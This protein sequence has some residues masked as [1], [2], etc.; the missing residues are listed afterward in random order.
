MTRTAR[1]R[2]TIRG[3]VAG[4]AALTAASAAPALAQCEVDKFA[5]SG[6]QQQDQFAY[7]L[8]VDGMVAVAGCLKCDHAA[9]ESGAAFILEY[10]GFG[11]VQV[12]QLQATD[13]QAFDH[14]GFD[15]D[16]SVVGQVAVAGAPDE[17]RPGLTNAGAAYVFYDG[18]S[19]WV[20]YVKLVAGDAAAGDRFGAS[21][22]AVD[23]VVVVGA[24]N[25]GSGGAVYVFRRTGPNWNQVQKLTAPD[26][27]PGAQFGYSVDFDGTTI[28]VGARFWDAPGAD[29]A[30][31]AYAFTPSGG[32]W[33]LADEL[34]SPDGVT[35]DH[36][37]SSVAV[38]GDNLVV[39]TPDDDD[40]GFNQNSNTGVA[41][42]YS[43]DGSSWSFVGKVLPPQTSHGF[44]T[45][46]SLSGSTLLVG[47][48]LDKTIGMDAGAAHVFELSEGTFQHAY[49]ILTSDHD[50]FDELGGAVA[51][52]GDLALV[53]ADFDDDQGWNSGAAYSFS[54][55]ER[56]CRPL[57]A[58]PDELSLAAGGAQT[59]AIDAGPGW[60][61]E[62]Y[63]VL[64]SL[65]TV[66]GF[67][68]SVYIPL[69][70]DIYFK[71]TAQQKNGPNFPN[72][73]GV[74]GPDGVTSSAFQIPPG[75]DAE[76]AGLELFHSFLIFD[77][78]TFDV[79]FASNL[80]S[81]V[82]GL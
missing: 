58:W 77:S 5:G 32:T 13:G 42:H 14:L 55:S 38:D 15:V 21:V 50:A 68:G 27:T 26:W 45:S 71:L 36:Y 48:F 30:G 34:V 76:L 28:V 66:G 10:D 57:Y 8:A 56:N 52:S 69:D 74:L 18:P 24:P 3:A 6:V 17:D 47:A 70:F 11:W 25:K 67:A 1:I 37:G 12:A 46:V 62:L 7:A 61:G 40:Q 9:G 64:G 78:V 59:W 22:A 82:L 44:G 60:D 20:Q 41:F 43:R 63:W 31:K 54:V 73:F 29:G 19:G 72:S 35:N 80:T 49:R 75:L 33:V 4:L 23:K 51:L 53:S 39:A 16:I 65:S 2:G 79:E 81:V